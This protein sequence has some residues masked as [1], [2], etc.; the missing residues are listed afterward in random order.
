MNYTHYD[1]GGLG[2]GRTVEVV[3]QG[4]SAN[5][6]LMDHENMVKYS[7]AKPFKAL[8]GLM[9]FSPIRLQTTSMAHWHVVVDMP[10]GIGSVKSSYRVLN[11]Q[12]PNIST[13]LATFKPTAEQ[14]RAI[15]GV[16]SPGIE[17]ESFEK[18]AIKQP[19][20]KPV[21]SDSPKPPKPEEAPCPKC[22]IL[23]IRG[24]YC[25]ECGAS[26]ERACPGCANISP[27]S[28]RF[29]YECGHKLL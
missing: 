3:L 26:M 17:L 15:S 25:T 20:L 14:K 10:K 13:T 18:P 21:V 6:Y 19:S 12:P 23:T 5:V 22:G 29:C 7:K 27:L 11:S 2:K 9:T 16:I 1:L 28:C 24:K 8:G 4:N